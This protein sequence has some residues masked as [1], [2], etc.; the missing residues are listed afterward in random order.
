ML[1]WYLMR[2]GGFFFFFSD[3]YLVYSSFFNVKL[4]FRILFRGGAFNY[5]FVFSNVWDNTCNTLRDM[6]W[7]GE[8]VDET[9][10]FLSHTLCA[11][12]WCLVNYFYDNLFISNTSLSLSQCIHLDLIKL[13]GSVAFFN[14]ILRKKY[15]FSR[16]L[17]RVKW[18]FKHSIQ[19]E[20]HWA[21][22]KAWGLC[23]MACGPHPYKRHRHRFAK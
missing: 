19:I 15:F 23:A 14:T 7:M 17:I 5:A 10:G 11:D 13:D 2:L 3:E 9:R 22:S 20:F 21:N 6:L 4:R 1:V 16:I 18:V 8:W 12:R